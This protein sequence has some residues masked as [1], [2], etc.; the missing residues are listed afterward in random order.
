MSI[1]EVGF[2]DDVKAGEGGWTT[3]GWYITD[4]I[5]AN[6]FSVT[7]IDTKWVPPASYPE[8]AGK[9]LMRLHS[10]SLLEVDPGT[11]SGTDK[12][13]STPSKSGRVQVSIVSNH[14]D[15][16]MQSHYVFSV[17]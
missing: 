10:I 12:I 9:N 4:G 1:P 15:H 3:T 16:E 11:Q 13:P 17:D 2:F 6:G 14:A 7:T 8:P 5:L